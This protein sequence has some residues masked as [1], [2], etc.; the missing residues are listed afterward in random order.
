MCVV[1]G[2]LIE[3]ESLMLVSGSF[4]HC[5]VINCGVAL[6]LPLPSHI[7]TRINKHAHTYTH[8]K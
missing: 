4:N 2:V 3:L 1:A 5:G 8:V 6:S 7:N